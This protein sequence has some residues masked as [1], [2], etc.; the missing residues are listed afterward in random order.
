MFKRLLAFLICVFLCPVFI[1]AAPRRISHDREAPSLSAE[2]AVLI[3]AN[4]GNILCEKNAHSRMAMASTTKIMTALI[5]AEK[6]DLE[7]VV[8]VSADAVGVEGSSIYLYAG[9]RITLGD[10]LSAML[11]ESANDA[12]AA[13]AIEIGGSI[14]GFCDMMNEKAAELGLT[15]THFMNPHGLFDEEHYTTAYE[16]A[17]IARE[18]MKNEVIKKTVSTR[19][20]IIKP[21]EG[22][23]R[24]L[25]NHNKMLAMYEGANGIKTGFTKKSGRCLIGSAERDG[26][27]LISVT[28][29]APDDWSDHRALFDFGFENFVSLKLAYKKKTCYMQDV[30]GGVEQALPLFYRDDVFVTIEKSSAERVKMVVETFNRYEI[31]PVCENKPVGRAV[32]LLDGEKIAEATLISAFSVERAKTDGGV[33]SK[34][35]NLFK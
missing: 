9:E 23:V 1:S 14:D 2:S 29:N 4:G 10:L 13:I 26:L 20:L 25:Y 17:I 32:W 27:L 18:A 21:V 33:F 22:N 31:A 16:L 35:I 3:E 24:A 6:G 7:R 34:I 5:A 19:K 30:M 28:L 11:L 8:S 15:D 12:A